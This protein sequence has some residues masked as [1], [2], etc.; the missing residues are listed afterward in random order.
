MPS[1]S[2]SL[3]AL[4]G[5][6]VAVSGSLTACASSSDEGQALSDTSDGASEELKA[7]V[8][9]DAQDKT[10]VDVQL[11]RSFTIALSSNASTGYLWSVKN[12]GTLKDPKAST[13]A[14]DPSRAGSPGIQK[15]VFSTKAVAPGLHNIT[16]E[17]KRASAS[18]S[19]PNKTFTVT[20]NVVE[21]SPA[22]ACGG[23]SGLVCGPDEYCEF[24]AKTACGSTG[25]AGSCA[26]RGRFCPQFVSTVCGCDGKQYG[27]SCF[28]NAAGASVAYAGPCVASP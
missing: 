9:G 6:L 28:A 5:L 24:D 19:S 14:G 13:V 8:I 27:N 18:S 7:A 23:S 26:T 3:V 17:Y 22:K 21:P 10:T 4:F 11:G 25:R 12:A 20:V 16:L 2:S 15:F 1:S